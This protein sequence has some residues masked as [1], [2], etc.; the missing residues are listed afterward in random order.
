MSDG[1]DP[2]QYDPDYNKP[3]NVKKREWWQVRDH[4]VCYGEMPSWTKD[5]HKLDNSLI[6]LLKRIRKQRRAEEESR[7]IPNNK[8]KMEMDKEM[9][10]PTLTIRYDLQVPDGWGEYEVLN[11][12]LRQVKDEVQSHVNSVL[13]GILALVEK[14]VNKEIKE[15][16]KFVYSTVE[17][18]GES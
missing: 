6:N 5:E 3:E 17:K 10:L 15:G 18:S 14:K 13:P 4:I 11:K 12:W 16:F 9:G 1:M 8:V 2:R 7:F